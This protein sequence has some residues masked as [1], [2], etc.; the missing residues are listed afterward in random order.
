LNGVFHEEQRAPGRIGQQEEAALRA[1]APMD[2]RALIVRRS[3][4]RIGAGEEGG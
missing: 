3:R 1:N 2:I 4:V